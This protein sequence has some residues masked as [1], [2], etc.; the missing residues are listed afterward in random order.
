MLAVISAALGALFFAGSL[1]RGHYAVWPGIIGGV[2]CAAVGTAAVRPLLA[3]VRARLDAQRR[4]RPAGVCRGL[5][6]VFAAL[7]I[8]APPLGLIGLLFLLWLL[9]AGRRREVRSTP[10]CES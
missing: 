9:F 1:G 4:R 3:R 6:V 2:I 8:V 10:A 5:G 7:S